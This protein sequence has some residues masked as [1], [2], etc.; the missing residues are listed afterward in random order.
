RWG[1]QLHPH[2]AALGTLGAALV[3]NG[4]VLAPG[5]IAQATDRPFKFDP[6]RL[7]L[8]DIHVEE[9]DVHKYVDEKVAQYFQLDHAWGAHVRSESLGSLSLPY[10]QLVPET[11]KKGLDWEAK[12]VAL[13]PNLSVRRVLVRLTP[14][15][16]RRVP[17]GGPPPPPRTGRER[18]ANGPRR[19]VRPAEP[20]P[21]PPGRL[22]IQCAMDA[23]KYDEALAPLKA[24]RDEELALFNDEMD[25]SLHTLRNHLL[26]IGLAT[27]AATV[28][29]GFW[30]VRLGLSPLQ[31]LSEAVS[32]ISARDFR[33]EF[34]NKRTPHELAPI[35]ERLAETLDQLKRAFAREKQAAADISHELR[36]PLAALLTTIDVTLR[37]PRNSEDYREALEDCRASGQ[38]MNLLV[39]RLLALARLDAGVDVLRPASVDASEL[40]EQCA[41]MVRPLAEARGLELRVHRNGPA[42]L[43]ADPAKLREVVTNLLHNAIQYNRPQGSVDLSVARR[44]GNLEVEVKDTGIG[45]STEARQHIFERFFRADPS[46]SADGLHAGLGLAIVKGYVDLMGGTI[47]V[48]S[49]EGQGSTFRVRLPAA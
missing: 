15:R 16:F 43:Q 29:G 17:G 28:V 18:D 21:L 36:T 11:N 25:G 37:K 3:P 41:S 20:L 33:L 31:K 40:A 6:Q 24:A 1:S 10:D 27:F 2:L 26:V 19:Q 47:A 38:Q 48:D 23:S 34:D 39:E 14:T 13:G 42:M 46:R 12:T 32:R 44:N 22:F 4:Y 5:W 45:I 49:T 30:L 35:A 9:E 7:K 8:M